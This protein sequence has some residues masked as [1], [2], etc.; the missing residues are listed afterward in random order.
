M[1]LDAWW[2]RVATAILPDGSAAPDEW[3]GA[4]AD[5][6]RATIREARLTALAQI[7]AAVHRVV[8][9]DCF[10]TWAGLYIDARPSRHV[11]LNRHGRD[12]P[13]WLRRHRSAG[14]LG[15]LD[16]LP[17][18]ARLERAVNDAYYAPD[19]PVGTPPGRTGPRVGPRVVPSL[20][21]IASHYPVDE[22]WR[23]NVAGGEAR[24][25]PGTS[26]WRRLVI[27]RRADQVAVE[28]VAPVIFRVL[29]HLAR[30]PGLDTLA[31]GALDPSAAAWLV[32]RRWIVDWESCIA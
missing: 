23:A 32:A 31:D 5:V 3:P 14:W 11:D 30:Q 27:W 22:I 13:A 25:V 10:R 4:R 28:A 9:P 29:R 1:Q 6:H 20:W 18:L 8:G 2:T 15:G 16:Y 26:R 17:D 19:D 24:Q 7:Y 12:F 21:T